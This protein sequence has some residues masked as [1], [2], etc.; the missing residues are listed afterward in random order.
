[1]F[2][3]ASLRLFNCQDAGDAIGWTMHLALASRWSPIVPSSG[4][5]IF[6]LGC[7]PSP[8]WSNA[9]KTEAKSCLGLH[10]YIPALL[11]LQLRKENQLWCLTRV[12]SLWCTWAA[13]R[14]TSLGR[15]WLG[16]L[17]KEG[18]TAFKEGTAM[19]DWGVL[20]QWA[21]CSGTQGQHGRDEGTSISTCKT[22]Q[23]RQRSITVSQCKCPLNWDIQYLHMLFL[24]WAHG[25]GWRSFLAIHSFFRL[26]QFV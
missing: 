24:F 15:G 20:L 26:L 9:I 25:P 21:W 11:Q 17:S 8:R 19:H 3:A 7:L 13:H 10:S 12:R 5:E 16:K 6:P 23:M 1:M 2:L 22:L 14:C 18:L 4:T